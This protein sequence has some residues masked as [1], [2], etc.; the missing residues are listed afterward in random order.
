LLNALLASD[1]PRG[2]IVLEDA[3][4]I[5]DPAVFEFID[6]MLERLPDHWGVVIASRI[7]PPLD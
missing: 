4:R 3:H 7:D 6:Q 2:L 1:V 5:A